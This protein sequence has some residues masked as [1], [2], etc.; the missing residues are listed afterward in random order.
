MTP[1]IRV[2]RPTANR[3][4]SNVLRGLPPDFN[5]TLSFVTVQL[6]PVQNT[7]IEYMLKGFS[8]ILCFKEIFEDWLLQSS[9]RALSP[10]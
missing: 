1:R 10:P 2:T 3:K 9:A 6:C 7:A 8:H 4:M 5:A